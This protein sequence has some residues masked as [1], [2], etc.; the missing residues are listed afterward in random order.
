[1]IPN[2]CSVPKEEMKSFYSKA[3]RAVPELTNLPAQLPSQAIAYPS[4]FFQLL[5]AL[6]NNAI[7]WIQT[8]TNKP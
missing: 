6:R 5:Q 8:S 7:S 3:G 2:P 4:P 1:M